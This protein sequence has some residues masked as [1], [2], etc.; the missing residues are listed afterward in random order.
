MS[1]DFSLALP[2]VEMQNNVCLP[3]SKRLVQNFISAASHKKTERGAGAWAQQLSS[4]TQR[5]SEK[6]GGRLLQ[7][8]KLERKFQEADFGSDSGTGPS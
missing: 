3:Q 4:D 8:A 2:S 5:V 6:A 1:V 7:K